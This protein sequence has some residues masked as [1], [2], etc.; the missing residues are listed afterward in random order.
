MKTAV[1][2]YGYLRTYK[3][4]KEALFKNLIEPNN[5]DIFIYTYDVEGVSALPLS[6]DNIDKEKTRHGKVQDMQ[7]DDVTLDVLNK[8]YGKVIKKAKIVH[9][10][11]QKYIDDTANIPSPCTPSYR[12]YSLYN[13]ITEVTKL[14]VDYV[15]E[16]GAQYDAVV[17]FRPDL[18]LYTKVEIDKL[19]LR[20]LNIPF[21]GGNLKIIGK[22]SLYYVAGYK[23]V[24]NAEYIPHEGVPFS[25]QFI[26]SSYDNMKPLST[27]YTK[28]YEYYTED[29]PTYH[30]E[31]TL[32]YHLG[33]KHNLH[34]SVQPFFYEILRNNYIET[35]NSF[36]CKS[37]QSNSY[38]IDKNDCK[39]KKMKQKKY[40]IKTYNDLFSILNGFK[41]FLIIPIHFAKYT[42]YKL[43]GK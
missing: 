39:E 13:S 12:I 33:F 41:S 42:L 40:K 19:D 32:Y 43:I 35:D 16:T 18:Q 15:N 31:S 23:N 26:I 21:V 8:T 2:L 6:T 27:L 25:D 29:F 1:L 11:P 5:A 30:A 20:A 10:D 17:L 3:V 7:G 22:N 9:Y 36:L 34:I 37:L 24:K 28:L 4:T 38:K 14:L